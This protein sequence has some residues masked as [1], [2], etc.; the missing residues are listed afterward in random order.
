MMDEIEG[1]SRCAYSKI[2]VFI[3][4]QLGQILNQYQ[5]MTQ[6][7]SAQV[8][9]V[10]KKMAWILYACAVCPLFCLFNLIII[11]PCSLFFL[12]LSSYRRRRASGRFI[13]LESHVGLLF[14]FVLFCSAGVDW[15]FLSSLRT[16]RFSSPHILPRPSSA[17]S[18]DF[19][20][21]TKLPPT[22]SS[23]FNLN[24]FAPFSNVSMP[25]T[26]SSLEIRVL[27]FFT[28]VVTLF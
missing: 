1:I 11:F 25:T 28:R 21:P 23:T 9:S 8:D 13:F 26:P 7:G 5:V 22:P 17:T 14:Y 16:F 18:L 15:I 3:I 6:G 12:S 19:G 2:L 27:F 10:E 20:H 24:S 4:N